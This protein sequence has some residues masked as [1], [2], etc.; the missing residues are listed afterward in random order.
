M[1]ATP[2]ADIARSPRATKQSPGTSAVMPRQAGLPQRI[3]QG[4]CRVTTFL[5]ISNSCG[6]CEEPEA[7]RQSPG[8]SA[9]MCKRES[10]EQ[11][12][13]PALLFVIPVQTGI[14]EDRGQPLIRRRGILK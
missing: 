10:L 3:E 13:R 14:Q 12:G 5:A 4:D 9:V 2:L 11:R 6:R 8:T 7:T 1:G